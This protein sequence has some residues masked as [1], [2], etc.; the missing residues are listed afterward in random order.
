[1]DKKLS[2]ITRAEWIAFQW[3]EITQIGDSERVFQRG[4]RCTPDE[5]REAQMEWDETA[6][7]RETVTE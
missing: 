2:N 5:A 4:Y 1:M 3:V 6:E 7:A